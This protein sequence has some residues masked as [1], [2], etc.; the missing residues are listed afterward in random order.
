M[1]SPYE[2]AE[3]AETSQ[4]DR[5]KQYRVVDRLYRQ[6]DES[7][8]WPIKGRFNVTNRAIKSARRYLYERGDLSA[9]EYSLVVDEIISDIVN[10]C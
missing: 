4:S 8:L 5:Q 7:H 9:L 3:V 1:R 10:H 6:Q 2:I